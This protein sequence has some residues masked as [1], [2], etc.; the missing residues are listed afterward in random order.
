M[1]R[2]LMGLLR[3]PLVQFV[4]IG[5]V[6]FAAWRLANPEAETAPTEIRVGASELKWLHDTWVGQFGHAPDAAEMASAVRGYVDEEM[7]YREGLALGLDADDTIVRRRLAQ[8][9]DFMLGA[10]AGD[11]I[12]TEAQLQAFLRKHAERY[13][14]PAKTSFC[15][16]WFGDQAAGLAAAQAALAALPP[17]M[18]ASPD[19][20]LAGR[21]GLPFARCYTAAVP[22]DVS[23]D[24]GVNFATVVDHRLPVG[25]WQGPVESGYG[26]HL[27]LI[28]RREPGPPGTLANARPQL[29][30][31]WR[32]Q[33]A[34]SAK[35][36]Q[37][38]DL[39]R[40]YKVTVD[41]AALRR[42]V[43]GGAR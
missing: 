29:E 10:E 28:T 5:A 1:R 42:L 25:T 24:F 3:Q 21:E 9:Y 14:L 38:A 7:R 19:A 39:R 4:L 35:A 43:E 11:L 2:R 41:D 16:V 40:R 22:V 15:Q 12:P 23:R 30:A 17:D 33:A 20:R 31:D 6:I 27:V 26:F 37:E 8:K 32:A 34:V 13:R 18:R 36:R